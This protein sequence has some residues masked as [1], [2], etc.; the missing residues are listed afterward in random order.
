V[1]EEVKKVLL[2]Y[3]AWC[4]DGDKWEGMI[5]KLTE[6]VEVYGYDQYCQGMSEAQKDLAVGMLYTCS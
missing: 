1:E 5:N 3:Q 6:L 2:E 4:P